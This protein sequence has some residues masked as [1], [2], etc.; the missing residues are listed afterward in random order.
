[1][2]IKWYC[3]S[4]QIDEWTFK[5]WRAN[6]GNEVNPMQSSA[7]TTRQEREGYLAFIPYPLPPNPEFALDAD[8]VLALTN[9][10]FHLGKLAQIADSI[11]NPALFA[12]MYLRREAILSSQIENISCTLDEVLEYEAGKGSPG[13]NEDVAQVVNYVRAY[14]T[15]LERLN[16]DKL[17]SALLKDLHSILLEGDADANPGAFRDRQNWIGRKGATVFEA[18]FVPPPQQEMLQALGNIDYFINEYQ[19][20][21][22]PLIRCALAHAQFET[23]HPFKDGNGRIGRLL[24]ALMLHQMKKLEKPLLFLSLYLLENRSEYYDRLM[25]VRSKGDWLGWVKFML[26]G[27]ELTAK[28]AVS[29]S[30]RLQALQEE[31]EKLTT[32]LPRMAPLLKMLYQYPILTSRG[33]QKNL[34]VALD[35]AIDWLKKFESLKILRET[36]GKRRGR[37]YRFDRYIDILDAGWTG[38]KM[39]AQ[40]RA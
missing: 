28:E 19:N 15:G 14:N 22:S 11:P 33:V 13:H 1:M 39:Q 5:R 25:S 36:T 3:R 26:L 31:M 29:M 21:M 12:G 9:A 2:S 30:D 34:G 27:I 35:T 10:E 17:T 4:W 32:D 7:G 40:A 38:R 6:E 24:I 8:G 18:D 16:A 20:P 23:V 37:I